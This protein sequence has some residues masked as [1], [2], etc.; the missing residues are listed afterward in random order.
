[1]IGDLAGF[2]AATFARGLPLFMIPTTLLAQ[3]DSSVGGKVGVNHPGAKN[4]I[5]AFH[6][7]AGVWIDTESLASLPDRELRCG[8]AEVVKYGVILDAAFFSELER[9]AER[10]LDRDGEALRRIVARSCRLKADV[11]ARDEREETGLRAVL[12]FGHTIGHAIEAVAGYDGPF[13]HGEAVAAGM[14]A[15]AWLAQRLGWVGP[16]IGD[17]LVCLL[18]RFGLPTKAPGLDPDRLIAA[19]SR[20][21]KNQ[22]GRLRFV[23]PRSIGNVE[24]TDAVS[25]TDVRAVLEAL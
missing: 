15:E 13:Q 3:V 22:G 20:D 5:G 8:L 1:V 7:P 19:M 18:E 10:I 12:N 17:R 11:V 21:K 14:L 6:Q 2:V 9:D 4:I 25:E 23:L 24:L 16:A